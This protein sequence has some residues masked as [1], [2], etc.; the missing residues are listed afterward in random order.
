MA[1]DD[2]DRLEDTV[3]DGETVVADLD[4]RGVRILEQPTVHPS[5]HDPEVNPS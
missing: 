1:L 5:V 2:L 4:R 3:A